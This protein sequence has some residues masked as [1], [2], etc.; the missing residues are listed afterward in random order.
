MQD[1]KFSITNTTKGKLPSLPFVSMKDAVLGKKYELSVVIVSRDKIKRLNFSHRGKNVPT[2][3]LSFP[4]S[5][6]SGEIFLNL[7]E[8][9]KEA[10]K[11]DR[12][13]ENFL[14]F[15]FIHGLV[16]LEGFEHGS[17]MEALERKYRAKFGI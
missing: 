8:A 9:K 4:L 3:I 1:S 11:F 2:D 10:K 6:T 17:R 16:H 14:G 13:F 5:E 7:D 15:L 12:K